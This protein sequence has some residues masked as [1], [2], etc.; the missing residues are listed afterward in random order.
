MQIQE[1]LDYAACGGQALHVWN[2]GQWPGDAP[3]CF[4]RSPIWGH[5]M[6]QD[7]KRLVATARRLGVRRVVVSKRDRREQHVDLC[8]APLRKAM[9]ETIR[10]RLALESS[11]DAAELAQSSGEDPVLKANAVNDLSEALERLWQRRRQREV[12]FGDMIAHLQGLLIGIE[13]ESLPTPHIDAIRRVLHG[14]SVRPKLTDPDAQDLESI[15][16]GAG[17]DVFR[18]LD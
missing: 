14:M 17:C 4:R 15:L 6:D 10:V 3:A 16:I 9:A 12:Q 7:E 2:G 13:P 8:G 18:E 1:A 11:I 5:L